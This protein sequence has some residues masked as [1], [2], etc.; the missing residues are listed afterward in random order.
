[1]KTYEFWTL[2]GRLLETAT[3]GDPDT[4]ASELSHFYGVDVDEIEWE[5]I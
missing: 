3:T 5:E 4:Y 2:A 1:M